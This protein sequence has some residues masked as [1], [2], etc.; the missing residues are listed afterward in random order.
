VIKKPRGRGGHSPRWAAEPEMMM[1]M[2]MMIFINYTIIICI[3]DNNQV[4]NKIMED[5]QALFCSSKFP[6]A[7]ERISLKFRDNLGT[8]PQISPAFP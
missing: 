7:R 1:M 5:S 4:I 2:M 8:H 6:W 3:N